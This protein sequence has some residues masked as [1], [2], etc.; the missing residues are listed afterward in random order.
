MLLS[1]NPVAKSFL[2]WAVIGFLRN[3]F[4]PQKPVK[5]LI[6]SL[7]EYLRYLNPSLW[8]LLDIPLETQTTDLEQVVTQFDFVLQALSKLENGIQQN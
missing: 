2:F 4:I 5:A 1:S 7:T 8:Q 3:P 6:L